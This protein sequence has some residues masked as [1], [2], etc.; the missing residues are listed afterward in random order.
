MTGVCIA[1][2]HDDTL[3]ARKE[4]VRVLMQDVDQRL[5]DRRERLVRFGGVAVGILLVFVLWLIPGYWSVRGTI[6]PALPVLFDQWILIGL[7]CFLIVKLG[8]R[9][10]RVASRFPYLTS[11]LTMT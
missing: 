8:G 11:D 3:D 10:F 2:R 6:Y 7:V 4:D 5:A 1:C 9:S